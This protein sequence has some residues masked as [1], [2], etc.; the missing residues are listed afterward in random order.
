[1]GGIL[2]GLNAEQGAYLDKLRGTG[3][4]TW[5]TVAE[6]IDRRTMPHDVHVAVM[7]YAGDMFS[8]TM[9]NVEADVYFC[10]ERQ[11]TYFG[12]FYLK[13]APAMGNPNYTISDHLTG[14]V[15][16]TMLTKLTTEQ[17]QVITSLVPA[18]YPLLQGVVNVRRAIATELRRYM[19]GETVDKA[20]VLALFEQYGELDGHI[21]HGD[22]LAFARVGRSLSTQQKAELAAMRQQIGVGVPQGAY[23]YSQPIAV[24]TIMDTDFLFGV[25]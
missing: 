24:P 8:W 20:K 9:G 25:K 5:P 2:H 4:A 17:A 16:Q 18:Q 11:G 3:M 22:A 23:L 15:G 7:T 6:P 10:P 12:G 1:M 13:D 19:V 14:D 21:I